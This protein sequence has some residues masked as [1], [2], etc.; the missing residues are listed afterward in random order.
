[1]ELSEHV[2]IGLTKPIHNFDHIIFTDNLLTQPK[3]RVL[4]SNP[5][6]LHLHAWLE[7]LLA[8]GAS[9]MVIGLV[10]QSH[11][12]STESI[13]NCRWTRWQSWCAEHSVMY[14]DPS[15]S[16]LANFRISLADKDKLSASTGYRSAI[17][18]AFRQCVG[19]NL[20]NVHLLHDVA[21]WG[22]SSS[23]GT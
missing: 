19:P 7:S 9:N 6:H 15:P 20:S 1:M 3:T 16:D 11:R 5:D 21:L 12:K 2:V 4:H 23:Q 18:T 22:S 10:A 8:S 13:Y 17:S 14:L